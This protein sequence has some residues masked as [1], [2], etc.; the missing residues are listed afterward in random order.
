MEYN[1]VTND[2][3]FRKINDS[4][5]NTIHN[6]KSDAHELNKIYDES[7]SFLVTSTVN[8]AYKNNPKIRNT[9]NILLENIGFPMSPRNLFGHNITINRHILEDLNNTNFQFKYRED[10]HNSNSWDSIISENILRFIYKQ[11]RDTIHDRARKQI[12][13]ET[14]TITPTKVTKYT[15]AQLITKGT[16]GVML[17]ICD[18]KKNS[19]FINMDAS[20][21]A[22][23]LLTLCNFVSEKLPTIKHGTIISSVDHISKL[24]NN[25]IVIT[26]NDNHTVT[27]DTTEYLP[28]SFECTVHDLEVINLYGKDKFIALLDG[29]D[30]DASGIKD[31]YDFEIDC[32]NYF[33]RIV[34]GCDTYNNLKIKLTNI[35]NSDDTSV[36]TLTNMFNATI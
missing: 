9:S 20:Q 26:L 30:I 6:I 21:S 18:S 23:Q 3:D 31:D 8:E 17:M 25:G 35:I 34:F 29:F 4:Y 1:P 36:D 5:S 14:S 16:D 11:R 33:R 15:S 27:I 32:E 12:M 19:E 24:L 2:K 7:V 22:Y 28:Y 13:L 10:L